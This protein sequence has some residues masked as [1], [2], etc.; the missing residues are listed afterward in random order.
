LS[1]MPRKFFRKYLPSHEAV[2]QN[3]YI[4]RF[5]TLLHHPNLWHLN[6]HS[7]AGGVAVGL[8]SGLVPGPFQMLTAAIL[9]VP[10]RVNLPVALATTLYTN[11][12]T[13]G[14]LYVIAYWIGTLFVP[15]DRAPFSHPPGFD[16][17]NLGAWLRASFDW[18]LSLG[19]PLAVGLVV[20]AL[21]L[22]IAGYVVVQLAWRAQ[23]V[24][25]WRRRRARRAG[26]EEG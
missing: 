13:I 3:R 19:K 23:V 17:S 6:R 25:A 20:L 2:R 4:A 10:L 24:V 11:P 18:M 9:A 21:G 26:R 8:F 22:A 7:V 1:A 12:L 16:W 14:P 15:G 5:G